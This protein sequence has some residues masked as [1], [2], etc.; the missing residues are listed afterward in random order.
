MNQSSTVVDYSVALKNYNRSIANPLTQ[1]V[2]R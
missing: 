1:A 2:V